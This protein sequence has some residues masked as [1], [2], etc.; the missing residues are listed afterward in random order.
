[1]ALEAPHFHFLEKSLAAKKN[2]NKT[3][4]TLP[5]NGHQ[6]NK[7]VLLP[8]G[9]PKSVFILHG[10]LAVRQNLP[11]NTGTVCGFNAMAPHEQGLLFA[12]EDQGLVVSRKDGSHDEKKDQR[13]A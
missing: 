3:K 7:G 2:R 5:P 12:Q 13:T 8:S 11:G 6:K 4:I 10:L 9:A 1:M